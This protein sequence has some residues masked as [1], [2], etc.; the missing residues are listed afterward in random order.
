MHMALQAMRIPKT[1]MGSDEPEI[2][3]YLQYLQVVKCLSLEQ[4]ENP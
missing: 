2:Q 1:G 4:K 3:R